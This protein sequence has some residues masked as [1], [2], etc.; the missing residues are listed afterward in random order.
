MMAFPLHVKLIGAEDGRRYAL[1]DV[2]EAPEYAVPTRAFQA[3]EIISQRLHLLVWTEENGW[4][5]HLDKTTGEPLLTES[6]VSGFQDRTKRVRCY[7]DLGVIANEE[8]MVAVFFGAEPLQEP[9]FS[10]PCCDV[11]DARTP[12]S[13]VSDPEHERFPIS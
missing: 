8:G 1:P 4:E 11:S 12:R 2:G 3:E 10:K 9:Y 7:G 5:K 6:P 13:D